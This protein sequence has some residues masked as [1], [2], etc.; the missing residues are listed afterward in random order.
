MDDQ[1]HCDVAVVKEIIPNGV[2][3]EVDRSGGC[4]SCAVSG[5]CF[6]KDKKVIWEIETELDLEAGDRVELII[7]PQARVF[8]S[9]LVFLVP[10][11]GLF[12]GYF[13]FSRFIAPSY[14]IGGAFFMMTASFLGVWFIDK[15]IGKRVAAKIG[16]KI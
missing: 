13:V 6:G 11:I 9:I 10:I 15:K 2:I 5:M 1:I 12:T 7:A 3:I 8:A 14:G 4:K 16:R